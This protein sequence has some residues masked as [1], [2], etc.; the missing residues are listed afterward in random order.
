MFD[1]AK[2]EPQISSSRF[3]AVR[4]PFL[5]FCPNFRVVNNS[6]VPGVQLIYQK[7][8]PVSHL[9]TQEFLDV[10]FLV[11]RK[12]LDESSTRMVVKLLY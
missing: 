6:P 4:H 1:L 3:S 9:F 5:I 2:G 12:P 10:L 8:I 7:R 11:Q